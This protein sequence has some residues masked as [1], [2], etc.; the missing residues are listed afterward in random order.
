M[1]R[2]AKCR[3]KDDNT[4]AGDKFCDT[5]TKPNATQICPTYNECDAK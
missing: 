5:K 4:H 3:R 2:R 1:K